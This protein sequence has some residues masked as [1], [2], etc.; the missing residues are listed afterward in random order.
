M[1]PGNLME[2]L[3]VLDRAADVDLVHSKYDLIDGEGRI[4]QQDAL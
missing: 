4:L 1:K 3:A 2:K